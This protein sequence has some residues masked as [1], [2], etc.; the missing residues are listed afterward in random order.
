MKKAGTVRQTDICVEEGDITQSDVDAIVNAANNHLWMGGGVAGAIKRAGGAD[1]QTEAVAKG[2]ISIGEAVATTAGALKAQYVIH[3]AVMGQ[4]LRTDSEK[5]AQAT[6]NCLKR[7]D[8]L[9][10]TSIAFPAF[11]TGV[12]GFPVAEAAQVM[13]DATKSYL[14]SASSSLEKVVF[15]LFGQGSYNTFDKVFSQRL[16]SNNRS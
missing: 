7:A 15:V 6:A 3:G 16:S 11:G 2:P 13:V 12:G 9:N 10:I 4:D 1:I 8:E 5:I 14:N